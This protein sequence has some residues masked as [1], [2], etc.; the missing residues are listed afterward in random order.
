MTNFLP[1]MNSSLQMSHFIHSFKIREGTFIFP[2]YFFFSSSSTSSFLFKFCCIFLSFFI[3]L[4]FSLPH[5]LTCPLLNLSRFHRR[6]RGFK[7][8]IFCEFTQEFNFTLWIL[9]AKK[10]NFFS[11]NEN[12][13][14]VREVKNKRKK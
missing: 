6:P 4:S 1:S 14:R 7:W 2:F 13:K 11:M 5:S 3:S 12:E 10:T 8:K 9:A